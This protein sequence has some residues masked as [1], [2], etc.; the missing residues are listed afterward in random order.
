MWDIRPVTPPRGSAQAGWAERR[1]ASA[2]M[3]LGARAAAELE[4]SRTV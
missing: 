4:L 3:A 1:V 2:G